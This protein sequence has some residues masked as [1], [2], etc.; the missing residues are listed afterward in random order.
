M[1]VPSPIAF[2]GDGR[3]DV[4]VIRTGDLSGTS[5]INYS[6]S[7]GTASEKS[8]YTTALGTLQFAPGESS[9]TVT[10]FITTDVFQES[11]ET[12][13]L[14]LSN[15]VGAQLVPSETAVIRIQDDDF[16]TPTANPIDST[17][18]FVRQHYRDFLNRDPDTAGFQFWS[19]EINSCGN[20][21]QCREIKRINVSAAFFLSIEFQETGFLA[22]RMYKVAYGDTTSPN[23]AVPVPIVRLTS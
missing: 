7:D 16:G 10:V 14:N 13:N 18:F 2:E 5:T 20:N 1:N 15:P 9:K 19:N 23:V 22:Y 4:S 17:A 11:Q 3:V 6:T 21:L 8:D 12:F